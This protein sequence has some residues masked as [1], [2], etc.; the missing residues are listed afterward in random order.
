MSMERVSTGVPGLDEMLCG[1]MMPGRA[2]LLV[3][4]PGAGKT[5]LSIQFL[6]EGISKNERCLYVA[7]EEQADMLKRDM[8][9]FGW[10]ISRIKILDTVQDISQGVWSLKAPAS[11]Q[12][13]DFSLKTLVESLR[14]LIQQYQPQR[15]VIDSLTSV[16]MLYGSQQQARREIMG[17]VNFLERSGC[18]TLLTS[19]LS[20]RHEIAIEEFLS[21]GVIKLHVLDRDGERVTGVSVGKMRGSDFDKHMRPFK[22]GDKGF[23]VFS[24][25]SVFC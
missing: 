21:S 9:V 25:E 10:D 6:L 18:T 3:G 20:S 22:I 8:G 4:G 5:I 11:V 14:S 15:I 13:Q 17:F 16:K 7:L 1:G 23:V 2:Y 19:E 12:K 24:T